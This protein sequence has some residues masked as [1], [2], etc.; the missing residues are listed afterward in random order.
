AGTARISAPFRLYWPVQRGVALSGGPLP[1]KIGPLWCF[2]AV[3]RWRPRGS[4]TTRHPLF[5]GV[6]MNVGRCL[7]LLPLVA[8][9]ALSGCRTRGD[10][11]VETDEL[12][13]DNQRLA[14]ENT[15]LRQK[16]A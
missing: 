5:P 6:T 13:S 3:T 12:R 15:E 2:S 7:L 9:L 10:S 4:A 16:N 1:S 11:S 14:K 8:V